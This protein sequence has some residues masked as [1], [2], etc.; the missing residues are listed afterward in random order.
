LIHVTNACLLLL[1]LLHLELLLLLLLTGR[2]GLTAAVYALVD[3]TYTCMLL[4]LLVEL[5]LC[6]LN[7]GR[8]AAADVFP[9]IHITYGRSLKLLATTGVAG[10]AAALSSSWVC[11]CWLAHSSSAP[12]AASAGIDALIDITD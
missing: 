12:A 5:W 11:S 9:T 3:I 6:S 4:L 2:N 10:T 8:V 7:L 1:L